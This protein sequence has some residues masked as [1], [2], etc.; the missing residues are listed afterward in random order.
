[1]SIFF[2]RYM[3]APRLHLI[4]LYISVGIFHLALLCQAIG[5]NTF[6]YYPIKTTDMQKDLPHQVTDGLRKENRMASGRGCI[7]IVLC[8]LGKSCVFFEAFS[9]SVNGEQEPSC[10]DT[11][12]CLSPLGL[13]EEIGPVSLRGLADMLMLL[14]SLA[15]LLNMCT[16]LGWAIFSS[17]PEKE[18]VLDQTF[19]NSILSSRQA[20]VSLAQR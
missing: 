1:M 15:F 11:F 16:A 14:V 8:D 18:F 5:Q 10:L 12:C 19:P 13:G 9:S 3:A 2:S 6:I 7:S 17:K 20:F 4:S